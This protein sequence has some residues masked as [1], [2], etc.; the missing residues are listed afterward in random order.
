MLDQ[1]GRLATGIQEAESKHQ[2]AITWLGN[3]N[4]PRDK[5]RAIKV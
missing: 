4:S 1:V 2:M 5:I 3:L